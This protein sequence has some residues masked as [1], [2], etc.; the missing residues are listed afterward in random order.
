[1]GFVLLRDHYCHIKTVNPS[2]FL[3]K[4]LFNARWILHKIYGEKWGYSRFNGRKFQRAYR[5]NY[6][7]L[8][9]LIMDS[10]L[11][12]KLSLQDIIAESFFR[13]E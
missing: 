6:F 10:Y 9:H 11:F 5:Q 2:K 13:E 8:V 3:A 1:M 12:A 4:I 7:H